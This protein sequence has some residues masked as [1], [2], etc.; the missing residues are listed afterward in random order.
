[1]P[2]ERPKVLI[3]AFACDPR[4]GSEPGLGY[5]YVRRLAEHCELTVMTEEMQN[6][7]P[8]E[9]ACRNDP[10]LREVRWQYVPWPSVAPDGRRNDGVNFLRYYHFYRCWQREAYKLAKTLVAAGDFDLV[11]HLTMTGFREPGYL[12]KLPVPFVW[13]PV[14]GH[15]MMPWRF[16]TT[17]GPR[18]MCQCGVRNVLNAV[19]MQTSPRVSKAARKAEVI[20]ASTSIDR[21]ALERLHSRRAV[22]LG[23]NGAGPTRSNQPRTRKQGQ[24]LRLGWSGLHIPRKALPI[25]LEALALLP[26]EVAVEVNILGQGPETARWKTL[27]RQLGVGGMCRFHGWL[28]RERALTLMGSLDALVITSLQ[29]AGSAVLFEALA[30]SLPVISHAACGFAD[31][32]TDGCSLLVPLESPSTSAR[33]FARAIARLFD[34]PDLYQ[35]LS[36]GAIARARELSWA[37]RAAIILQNY[38][39]LLDSSK[40]KRISQ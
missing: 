20:F 36:A 13:G 31:A 26:P 6:R 24:P 3:S 14:G 29:D 30:L 15:V 38:K 1:M 10:V 4:K 33:L 35:R 17:L 8:I 37:R 27:A 5:N 39:S 28:P 9:E 18:G 19:Q 16:L 21:I 12:W 7:G 23:E 22:L 40:T 25:L 32:L 34:E 2:A 11:H